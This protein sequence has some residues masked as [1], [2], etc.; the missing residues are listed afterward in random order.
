MFERIERDADR[1]APVPVWRG[2]L[3]FEMHRGTLTSQLKTK[4]GNRRCERLLVEAELWAATLGRS[5]DVDD[6]WKRV[7]TQQFHDILPGSSIAW[8]HQDAEAEFAAVEAELQRRIIDLLGEMGTGD[9]RLI[10]NPADAPIDEVVTL[11][12]AGDLASDL[13]G[14]T[15]R[16]SDGTLACRITAPA[17][18]LTEAVA[19][20][21]EDR[22]VLSDTSMTNAHLAVRW[23][24]LGN[25]TSII[26]LAHARELVP[27]GSFAAVLELAPDHPVEY[28]AWDLESWTRAGAQPLTGAQSVDVTIVDAGPLVGRVRVARAFGP[29]SSVVTYELRAGS[30]QLLVHVELD[31]HHDEHLLSMAFPL[32]VRTDTAM[33]DIQFG[34][35]AR[36]THPSS[37]WDAAKFEV[38][39]H[40]FVDLSEPNFGVAVLNTGRYG[41]HVFDGGVRVSLARAAKYPD[42]GADHGHHEVTLALR[43]HGPGLAEC[44]RRR[45]PAERTVA[46]RGRGHR[47][48][49]G[50]DG[51]GGRRRRGLGDR[52]RCRE[53]RR[54]RQRRPDRAAARGVRRSGPRLGGL[55]P[56]DPGGVALQPVGGG[57]RWRRGGRRHRRTHAASVRDR[58]AAASPSVRLRRPVAHRLS[59]CLRPERRL[60]PERGGGAPRPRRAP[61]P[62]PWPTRR[63]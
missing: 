2:E 35:V 58:D 59:R 40:R 11:D 61:C 4:L 55:R 19:Q 38:C 39:A 27:A 25:L 1:G 5:A 45:R 42:P 46:G 37:P 22:V 26:D 17:L 52:G 18:G 16:L 6:L 47:A 24:A 20:P 34:V 23:D 43:P 13:D 12:V 51:V 56:A 3:Y 60:R 50:P 49:P 31:W 44:P 8:V 30:P 28:D 36:P 63:T 15:Q 29:S 33:C 14:R 7:L 62:W 9:G 48:V 57:T 53:A 10:A 21:V 41:H 32:D 54:R